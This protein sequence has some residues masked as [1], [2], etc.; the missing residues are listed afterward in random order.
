MWICEEFCTNLFVV[1]RCFLQLFNLQSI[2]FLFQELPHV[3]MVPTQK[4]EQLQDAQVMYY[5]W[6]L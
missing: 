3:K 4:Q 5:I 6:F 1:D 2:G